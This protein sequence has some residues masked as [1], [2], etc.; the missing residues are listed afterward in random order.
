MAW[1]D[2]S[3]C[4]AISWAVLGLAYLGK[5]VLISVQGECGVLPNKK[6]GEPWLAVGLKEERESRLSISSAPST[7]GWALI[8]HRHEFR[9]H[10]VRLRGENMCRGTTAYGELWHC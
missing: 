7:H 8:R 10:I 4:K 6:F 3:P 1:R 5:R 2:S 9:T